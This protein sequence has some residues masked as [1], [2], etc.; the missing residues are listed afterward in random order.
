MRPSSKNWYASYSHERSPRWPPHGSPRSFLSQPG[1]PY[2]SRAGDEM[3]NSLCI[4]GKGREEIWDHLCWVEWKHSSSPQTTFLWGTVCS[5]SQK[6]RFIKNRMYREGAL[7]SGCPMLQD[8]AFHTISPCSLVLKLSMCKGGISQRKF[9]CMLHITLSMLSLGGPK[10]L[11]CGSCSFASAWWPPEKAENFQ[12][13][14]D[15]GWIGW[16]QAEGFILV[17]GKGT[18]NPQCWRSGRWGK[19]TEQNRNGI[20]PTVTLLSWDE[21]KRMPHL[22]GGKQDFQLVDND[23]QLSVFPLCQAFVYSTHLQLNWFNLSILLKPEFKTC[24]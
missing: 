11:P 13:G 19:R 24:A 8:L 10:Q 1:S 21:P 4:G 15:R 22:T 23:W 3:C 9:L 18:W 14:A 6:K 2:V 17:K 7:T 20:I 12:G 5:F 16:I